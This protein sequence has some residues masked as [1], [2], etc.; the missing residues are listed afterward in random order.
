MVDG[1][2]A[3]FDVS[4]AAEP[5]ARVECSLTVVQNVVYEQP[6]IRP[7]STVPTWG[8]LLGTVGPYKMAR[9]DRQATHLSLNLLS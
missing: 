8:P 4:S 1:Q 5:V 6:L 3:Q 2:P 9:R 7:A